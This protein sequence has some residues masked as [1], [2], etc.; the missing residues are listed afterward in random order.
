MV[1]AMAQSASAVRP[2][3]RTEPPA[4]RA[5]LAVP[6]P[7]TG[8]LLAG[9]MMIGMGLGLPFAAEAKLPAGLSKRSENPYADVMKSK[10]SSAS[11]EEL[12]AVSALAVSGVLVHPPPP[13]SPYPGSVCLPWLTPSRLHPFRKE[14]APAGQGSSC[15]GRCRSALTVFAWIPPSVT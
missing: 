8:D 1:M 7:R 3:T 4:P 14:E 12:Y 5:S 15:R 9:A 6:L 13:P 10:T 11:A 2:P